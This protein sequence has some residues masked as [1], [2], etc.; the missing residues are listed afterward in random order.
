[1][2]GR[3]ENHG[4][5]LT[6]D[7]PQGQRGMIPGPIPFSLNGFPLSL[8]SDRRRGDLDRLADVTPSRE[9][10]RIGEV[11]ALLG[12]HRLDRALVAFQ[13]KTGPILPVDQGKAAAIRPET[14]VV[15]DEVILLHTDMS[16]DCSDLIFRHADESG[17]SAARRASLAEISRRHGKSRCLGGGLWVVR[18]TIGVKMNRRR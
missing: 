16:G 14:R 11:F 18:S 12:L 8:A 4:K 17:P 7:R 15:L 5:G 13:K 6:G 3:S 9:V 10:P 1:M 2:F